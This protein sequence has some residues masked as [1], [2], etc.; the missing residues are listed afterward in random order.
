M[1]TDNLGTNRLVRKQDRGPQGAGGAAGGGGRPGEC[2]GSREEP[3]SL[4]ST[5]SSPSPRGVVPPLHSCLHAAR[6]LEPTF[7]RGKPVCALLRPLITRRGPSSK[8]YTHFTLVYLESQS[9]AFRTS[10]SM[11]FK[12]LIMHLPYLGS[13]QP[14]SVLFVFIASLAKMLGFNDTGEYGRRIR[15]SLSKMLT[16]QAERRCCSLNVER[17]TNITIQIKV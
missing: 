10:Q 14:S 11:D 17:A 16:Y 5:T 13:L 4:H 3:T 7:C 1:E 8:S 15:A 2:I 9:G 6:G 12:K